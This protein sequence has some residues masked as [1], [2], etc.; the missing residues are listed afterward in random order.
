MAT[1]VNVGKEDIRWQCYSLILESRLHVEQ[2]GADKW[3]AA[4]ERAAEAIKLAAEHNQT[5]CLVDAYIARG[6]ARHS[7]RSFADARSDFQA[8]LNQQR[9]A[10]QRRS[11]TSS[12]RLGITRQTLDLWERKFRSE[13]TDDDT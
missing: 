13:S 4:E 3:Q 5:A 10:A 11:E 8:A 2:S 1:I 9:E 12:K 7:M 6:R